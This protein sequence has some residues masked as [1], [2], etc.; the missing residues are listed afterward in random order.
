MR[1]PCLILA[2]LLLTGCMGSGLEDLEE[3]VRDSDKDLRGNIP[4]APEVKP[5]EV[6]TYLNDNVPPLPTPFQPRKQDK[7]GKDNLAEDHPKE[8]LESFPLENLKMV[9]YLE[10]G[11]VREAV[12][13]SPD[14]RIFRVK[15]GNYIG[16]K[17][18]RITA[19]SPNA[20][21]ISEIV[22]ENEEDAQHINTLQLEE[23]GATR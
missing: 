14:G 16:T 7:G 15:V 12:I 5:P 18:G 9:G 17:F 21:T 4:P 11:S 23:P 19:V 3:F 22:R 13:R 8:E 20:I 6:F 1:Y 2:S 10:R